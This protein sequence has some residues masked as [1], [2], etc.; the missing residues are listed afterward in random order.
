MCWDKAVLFSYFGSRVLDM[1]LE[2]RCLKVGAVK[3]MFS[4]QVCGLTCSDSGL[5]Y[6]VY[7]YI[8]MYIC[9]NTLKAKAEDLSWTKPKA[10]DL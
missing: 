8:C 4:L 10:R 3:P 6:D 2:K 9:V 5:I 1:W 7:I